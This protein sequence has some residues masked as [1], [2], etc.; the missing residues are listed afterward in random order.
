VPSALKPDFDLQGACPRSLR[1]SPLILLALLACTAEEPA[2][3]A[4]T[5]VTFNTGTTEGLDHDGSPDDGY[6]SVHAGY[7][8]LHYGDGLAWTPAVDAAARFFTELQP[9]VV[10]LQEIFHTRGCADVPPEARAGF[11]CEGHATGDPTV[12]QQVLGAG[13]QI[14][15]H[16][17]K[18][19]KCVA[20]NRSFGRIRGCTGDICLDG[21]AG[22]RVPD[23][24]GGSRVARA[25]IELTTGDLLTVVHIHGSSGI[26]TDDQACRAKQFDQVF[27]DLGDGAPGANGARNV[28]LGDLNVDPARLPDDLGAERF[29]A[30]VGPGNPFKLVTDAGDDAE[31][32]YAGLVNIDHIASDALTGD[33]WTAGVT[34]GRDAVYDGVYFDHKPSVCE[35]AER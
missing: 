5:A 9:E 18:D 4:F 10:G 8:D 15:C 11:V 3:L 1:T 33:C 6:T 20:V 17:G 13:Y 16:L 26:T 12:A 14:A 28:I 29:N 23:C 24:G 34:A 32:T 21:L 2:P 25:E 7:S 22:S 27:V 35:L 30:F 19:D 31:P